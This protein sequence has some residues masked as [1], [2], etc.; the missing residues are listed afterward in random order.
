[1]QPGVTTDEIDRAV[2]QM[3][4]D[5]GA[6]PSPLRY[7]AQALLEALALE[8]EAYQIRLIFI[9]TVPVL[10]WFTAWDLSRSQHCRRPPADVWL[11]NNTKQSQENQLNLCGAGS[12]PKSVCTSINECICHGIPDSRSLRDGDIVNIDVTVFLNV[13]SN[14]ANGSADLHGNAL[15]A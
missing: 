13:R 4:I 10:L 9:E 2:H 6:Y 3:V 7:G 11:Q 8:A 5:A 12:F 1:M 15:V 14:P